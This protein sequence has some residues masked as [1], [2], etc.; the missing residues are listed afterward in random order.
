MKKLF[1]SHAMS[2][3]AQTL[4][5]LQTMPT[6]EPLSVEL[7]ACCNFISSLIHTCSI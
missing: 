1:S 5:F 2:H 4:N 3:Q 7:L 6:H